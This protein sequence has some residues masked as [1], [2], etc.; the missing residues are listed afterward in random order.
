MELVHC[1]NVELTL[2]GPVPVVQIDLSR[3]I[4]LLFKDAGSRPKVVNAS[5]AGIVAVDVRHDREETIPTTMFG[6]QLISYFKRVDDGEWQLET[7]SAEERKAK[8]GG[9]YVDLA[10]VSG[11]EVDLTALAEKSK[12]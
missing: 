9:G 6:D 11:S 3:Q 10:G 8:D 5:N 7:I 1:H 2:R 4:R 12:K